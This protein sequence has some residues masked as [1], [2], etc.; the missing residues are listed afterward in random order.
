MNPHVKIVVRASNFNNNSLHVAKQAGRTARMFDDE[1]SVKMFVD[2]FSSVRLL[3]FK[4]IDWLNQTL[5]NLLVWEHAPEIYVAAP[6]T[7]EDVTGLYAP[8]YKIVMNED[9][10]YAEFTEIES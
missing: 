8:K 5:E 3:C 6:T 9:A 7:Q 1:P 4:D 10:D 2:D